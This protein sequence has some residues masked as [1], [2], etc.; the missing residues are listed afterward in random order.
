MT[1]DYDTTMIS[2]SD[3]QAVGK[4][5]ALRKNLR[6]LV[7]E[8]HQYKISPPRDNYKYW[9]TNLPKQK[10]EYSRGKITGKSEE[11]VYLK[12]AEYYGIYKP[13]GTTVKD[14]FYEWF[15]QRLE[16]GLKKQTY[17]RNVYSFNR[18][19]VSTGW[20]KRSMDNLTKKDIKWFLEG[21]VRGKIS[22]HVGTRL[23]KKQYYRLVAVTKAIVNQAYAND[24]VDYYWDEVAAMIN[25]ADGAFAKKEKDEISE[26]YT[27]EEITKIIE[28]CKKEDDPKADC[29]LLMIITGLRVGEAVALTHEDINPVDMTVS[30]SKTEQKTKEGTS[31]GNHTKTE[32]GVRVVPVLPSYRQFLAELYF[33]SSS[34]QYLFVYKRKSKWGDGNRVQ[35]RSIERYVKQICEKTGIEYK[36]THA[37]R[38]HYASLLKKCGVDDEIR[39]ALMGHKEITT[40][41]QHYDRLISSPDEVIKA[42]SAVVGV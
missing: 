2:A 12:L 24:L 15:D 29:V 34:N 22:P 14:M 30:V 33:K 3:G 13:K 17:D 18:F 16:D 23:T 26:V 27:T 35:S 21:N 9:S 25:L 10:G 5:A 38:K 39:K 36:G 19:Y 6:K 4:E 31:V 32:K 20:H 28:Y 1:N 11:E 40:T 42:L 37:L 8:V 7:D 41:Q